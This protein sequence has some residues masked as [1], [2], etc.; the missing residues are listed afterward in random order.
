MN[1]REAKAIELA[2]RGRVVKQADHWLVF[3]LTSAE[4][5]R[6]SLSPLSCSCPDFELR[7]DGCKH[8]MAAR[9]TL[10][11]EGSD[12]RTEQKPEEPPI[13]WPRKTY[14][15]DW[16]V[17]NA[18]QKAE[19]AEFLQLLSDLC[20]DIEEPERKPG[21]GRPPA[22]L[23]DQAFAACF[24]VFSTLSGRR[25]MTD[26]QDAQEKGHVGQ[27]VAHNSIARFLMLRRSCAGW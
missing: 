7:Q 1:A 14:A 22:S 10:S 6:V 11:R 20:V 16:P 19:K 17:Y 8:T 21:R 15:Q 3:S 4:K 12:F 27:A 24:K 26:L 23:A 2:D 18:A 25:F 13:V 5:Y 9:I